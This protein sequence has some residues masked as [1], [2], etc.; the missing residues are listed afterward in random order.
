M[1][2]VWLQKQIRENLEARQRE[3]QE[4]DNQQGFAQVQLKEEKNK[5][6][7]HIFWGFWIAETGPGLS[8]WSI[9]RQGF[10]R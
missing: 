3:Q 1:Y 8:W 9:C 6:Q 10:K 5:L 7:Q 2:N 4:W